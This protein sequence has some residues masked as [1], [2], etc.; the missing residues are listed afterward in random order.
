MPS[1]LRPIPGPARPTLSGRPCGGELRRRPRADSPALRPSSAYCSSWIALARSQSEAV[2]SSGYHC[3]DPE[4][5]LGGQATRSRPRSSWRG[6]WGVS[7]AVVGPEQRLGPAVD[8]GGL[9]A[10][11]VARDPGVHPLVLPR[12]PRPEDNLCPLGD[13]SGIDSVVTA[14]GRRGTS[15]IRYSAG[16]LGTGTLV[17]RSSSV[18]TAKVRHCSAL[19]NAVRR[20]ESRPSWASVR[21][22]SQ[23]SAPSGKTGNPGERGGQVVLG[24]ADQVQRELLKDQ[25]D[26]EQIAVVRDCAGPALAAGTSL[27]QPCLCMA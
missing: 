19:P 1:R 11:R 20:A 13:P 15:T 18:R 17:R 12:G 9:G 5:R 25:M 2:P 21:W 8:P 24:F 6:G 7:F 16:S 22:I 3:G 26:Y 4:P 14:L 27:G 23:L 10:L